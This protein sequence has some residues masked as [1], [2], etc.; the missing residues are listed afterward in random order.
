MY[1]YIIYVAYWYVVCFSRWPLFLYWTKTPIYAA[2]HWKSKC[3][4]SV[5]STQE[6]CIKMVCK[7]QKIRWWLGFLV[8]SGWGCSQ[9]GKYDIEMQKKKKK[10]CNLTTVLIPIL[11]L[12]LIPMP[13]AK[14]SDESIIVQG[15]IST[16][17]SGELSTQKKDL[18]RMMSFVH[19]RGRITIFRYKISLV[20]QHSIYLQ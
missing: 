14:Y 20:D 6:L 13:E 4:V 9:P 19:Q 3:V 2:V 11:C 18:H 15:C 8:H 10:I 5:I 1:I 7:A 17:R 16:G 12:I